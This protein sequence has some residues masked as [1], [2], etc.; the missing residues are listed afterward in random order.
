MVGPDRARLRLGRRNRRLLF[1][2]FV[3]FAVSFVSRHF[4][5]PVKRKTETTK[6]TKHTKH[7]EK[8]TV[9][10]RSIL[11]PIISTR[12]TLAALEL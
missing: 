3:Y 4:E 6:Y 12:M 1:V 8:K 5:Y 9:S 11:H 10:P 2:W 7:H